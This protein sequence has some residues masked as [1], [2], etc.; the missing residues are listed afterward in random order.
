MA[1]IKNI[2]VGL[3][4]TT[5]DDTLINYANWLAQTLKIE[6]VYFVH[7][8]KKYEISDLFKEQLAEVDLE[9]AIGDELTEKIETVFTEDIPFKVLISEDSYT[10][11]LMSYVVTK[12]QIDLSVFG[13]KAGTKG[14]GV[15]TSKLLRVLQCPL[16]F[17]PEGASW[18]LEKIWAGIDFSKYSSWIFNTI[19]FIEER[20]HA[21][22]CAAHVYQIPAQFSNYVSLETMKTK[23]EKHTRERL[24]KLKKKLDRTYPVETRAIDS[25][26]STIAQNLIKGAQSDKADLI[27][28]G[29]KGSNTLYSL[30]VGNVAD[31]I[32]D[33]PSTIPIWVV[34]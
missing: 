25:R 32:S 11:S 5:M 22:V 2:L 26:E 16:V 27:I 6:N 34:K 28:I 10:E 4:L 8:V 9:T 17:V 31:E 13:N 20:T 3:D 14:T 15:I 24:E 21:T 18:K 19:D 7:N 23:L 33:S 12:Y 1:N 30:L 29:D